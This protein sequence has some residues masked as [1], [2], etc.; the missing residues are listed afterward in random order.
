MP[1]PNYFLV[2]LLLVSMCAPFA[3]A[4]APVPKP[5]PELSKLD[6]LAGHWTTEGDLKPGPM[7]PGGKVTSIDDSE[8]MDGKFFLVMRSKFSGASGD[9]TGLAIFGYDSVNKVY[10]YNSFNSAGEADHYTGTLDG[11]TLTWSG[12]VPVGDKRLNTRYVTKQ[13]SPTSYTYRFEITPDGTSWI[14]VMDGKGTKK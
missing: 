10:T 9:V 12:S 6:Y 13:L 5:A 2:C 1:R 11:D 8:W 4:Q 14:L 3:V 7:G